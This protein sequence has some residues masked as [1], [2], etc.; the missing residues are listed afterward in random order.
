[1]SQLRKSSSVVSQFFQQLSDT[2]FDPTL[3]GLTPKLE[4]FVEAHFA[5]KGTAKWEGNES[6]GIR[7]H[8]AEWLLSD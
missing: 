1:M 4:T 8:S 6:V 2:A 3:S 7:R 5:G